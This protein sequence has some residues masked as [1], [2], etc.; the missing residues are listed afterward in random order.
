MSSD[1]DDEGPDTKKRRLDPILLVFVALVAAGIAVVVVVSRMSVIAS[2]SDAG[3]LASADAGAPPLP[4]PDLPDNL[5]EKPVTTEKGKLM[6][7]AMKKRAQ[8]QQ[9]PKVASVPSSSSSSSGGLQDVVLYGDY[10]LRRTIVNK[11]HGIHLVDGSAH[12]YMLSLRADNGENAG[13]IY[14][15]CSAAVLELPKKKLVASLSSEAD[16]GKGAE[17]QAA[18]ACAASLADDLNGWLRAHR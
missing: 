4:P 14:A 12:G 9:P 7:E 16:G 5:D 8:K 1:F 15:K 10:T 17:K 13:G 6:K 3:A 2:T 18:D 11:L